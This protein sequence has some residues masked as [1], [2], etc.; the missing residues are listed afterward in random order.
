MIVKTLLA[1]VVAGLIAG[2]FMTGA[3]ELR[4]TPLILHAEEFEGEAP[5]ATGQPA[6]EQPATDHQQHSSLKGSQ[7]LG[8]MLAALSPVTPAYAHEGEE[9]EEGGIMF[10]MSRFSGT[11]AANLVTGA[12]FSLLLAGISLMIGYPITLAN[13]ALWGAFGWLAVHLLPAV[14]LPPEL[15]GFPA[16]ELGDRQLWWG[17]TVLLSAVGLYL[18][19]L[20]PEIVA[21]LAGLVLVAAPHLYGA[22]QPLDI[23]SN[24]PAV[25]G[26]EFAVA[27][28]ATTLAFWL[29]LG[30]VSG[31]I[32]DRF[33]RAH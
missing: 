9:H 31:F 30:I 8:E 28:L 20:R 18:L 21:K 13:G 22:P 26:A 27:A 2:V 12:G 33:L 19:A 5:A 24:V 29:V 11:L 10:G 1:A 16:A 23:S 4:V 3:Q 17:A 6:G 7:M 14:G 32:N 15:P 25:L